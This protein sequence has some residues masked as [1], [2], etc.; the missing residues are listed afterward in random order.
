MK[1]ERDLERVIYHWQY[2]SRWQRFKISWFARWE[3]LKFQ[4]VEFITGE[5]NDE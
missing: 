4:I 3:A 5:V 1:R 2:I